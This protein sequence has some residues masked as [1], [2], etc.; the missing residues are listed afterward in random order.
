MGAL[1]VARLAPLFVVLGI[2]KHVVRIDRLARWAWQTPGPT[3]REPR[4]ARRLVSLVLRLGA[5]AGQPDRDCLQR[6]LLLYRELSRAGADP[7]LHVAFRREN[8][9][10]VGHAWVECAGRPVTTESIAPA[11]FDVTWIFGPDGRL[12]KASPD[13]AVRAS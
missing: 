4:D 9:R 13:R 6:S 10:L 12:L 11:A 3:P 8:V 2:A 7:R 1:I 5:L